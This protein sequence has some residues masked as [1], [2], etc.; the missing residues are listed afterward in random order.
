M[1]GRDLR[2]EWRSV[3]SEFRLEALNIIARQLTAED[4]FQRCMI[5]SRIGGLGKMS[6]IFISAF[7]TAILV[8][9]W[10]QVAAS[11]HEGG[12][13]VFVEDDIR[14]IRNNIRSKAG[15][16][17]ITERILSQVTS[18]NIPTVAIN[19]HQ[20]KQWVEANEIMKNIESLK[21]DQ[22]VGKLLK[23]LTDR[24][25]SVFAVNVE[26][27]RDFVY[28]LRS[29]A[30]RNSYEYNLIEKIITFQREKSG[31]VFSKTDFSEVPLAVFYDNGGFYFDVDSDV[32]RTKADAKSDIDLYT[33][34]L[35]K[36]PDSQIKIIN[37][38]LIAKWKQE[39]SETETLLNEELDKIKA[40]VK[41]LQQ[42]L[43]KKVDEYNAIQ[44]QKDAARTQ[45]DQSLIY[46][47]YGMI[48]VLLLLFLGLKIFSDQV[49]IS[50]IENRSLVEVVGMAFML[51][52][53]IILGTGE[54]LSKEILGTLLGTI[55]G[56]VFARSTEDKKE[57]RNVK[58]KPITDPENNPGTD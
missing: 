32:Q 37:P 7:V 27:T 43:T 45:T 55:A 23:K 33:S 35:V 25:Y 15:N 46:A 53:I 47:V 38:I 13:D 19:T 39:K 29:R 17:R 3:F 58:K 1:A 40:E 2:A 22:Y 21:D 14:F 10:P 11:T 48:L 57:N 56:Y 34:I 42:L 51:I 4:D 44:Q 8:F 49:A 52:T 5:S 12:F 50:L 36:D 20:T 41:E 54:K 24:L 18:F 31:S 9:Y 30:E 28:R 6:K 26:T 16:A